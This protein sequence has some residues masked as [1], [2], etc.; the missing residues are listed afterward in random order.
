MVVTGNYTDARYRTVIGEGYDGVVKVSSGNYYGT[1]VLLYTGLAGLTAA[2]LFKGQIN[3]SVS[4][5]FQTSAGTQ[6]VSAN[7]AAIHPDYD[8]IN[9]NNDLAIVWLNASAPTAANRYNLYRNS[10][11]I[12]QNITMV[13]Y[14]KTGTG[15]TGS[16]IENNNNTRIQA[17]NTFEADAS[18]F[19]V[20]LGSGIAWTPLLGTQLVADFD[21]GNSANDALGRLLGIVNTGLGQDEGLVAPGDSGGP[22]FINNKIAGIASYTAS[23]SIGYIH[24]DVDS[25]TNSS[26]GEIAAWQRVSNYQQWIDQSI[27]AQYPNAPTK[28]SEVQKQVTE[29][30]SGTSYAYFL[31]QFTGVRADSNQILSVDYTTRDGTATA[32]Q[33]Y[34]AQQ[35]TLVIYPNET[36][37]VVAIEIIGDTTPEP[38][39][40]FYL[41]I[42]HPVGGSFGDG[43]S[44]LTAIRTI[45]SNDGWVV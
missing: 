37:T 12:G 31:L 29:G 26:F 40:T 33:D 38:D 20:S 22:A 34:I 30:N 27:R 15:Q 25:P 13:G 42:Y 19:K 44:S 8:S 3:P 6:A 23:L 41:D 18:A 43:I 11:E 14:G 16:T 2:H 17:Q 4:I 7:S 5:T 39:E 9:S 28:A 36:Q 24:P 45:L 32:G 21:N 1:G 35:G 10:D